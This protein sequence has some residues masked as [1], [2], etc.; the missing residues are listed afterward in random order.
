MKLGAEKWIDYKETK[1]LVKDIRDATGGH[2]PNVAVVTAA[3][4]DAYS[5]AID[6]LR[7]GG[8]LMVVG[9]PATATLNADI[10]F[11]VTKSINILGSYVG[12][13][14]AAA[15]VIFSSPVSKASHSNRQDAYEALDIAASGKVKCFHD[16][17]P[18]SALKEYVTRLAAV[19]ILYCAY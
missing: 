13:V 17:K 16:V 9:L 10:F 2:G 5:Q 18:L 14:I 1:D 6:Y 3:T 7:P 12:Y 19:A 8:T 15:C 4:S 11:T